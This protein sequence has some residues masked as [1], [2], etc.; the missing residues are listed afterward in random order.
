MRAVY[1]QDESQDR[2][3][4]QK[5]L[6]KVINDD[7]SGFFSKLVRLEQATLA[8]KSSSA[9]TKPAESDPEPKYDPG[10]EACQKLLDRLLRG[11]SETTR[12]V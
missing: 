12:E 10:V 5:M 1:R 4:G 3:P 8:V 2:T 9:K 6:R 11:P 7:P